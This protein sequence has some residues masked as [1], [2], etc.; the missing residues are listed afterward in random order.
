MFA[1]L[2]NMI[3]LDLISYGDSLKY[4]QINGLSHLWDPIR[5]KYVRNAPEELVRQLLLKHLI[6]TMSYSKRLIQVEKQLMVNDLVRRFDVL[7][8][9]K[10][11][12]PFL[13]VECKA[14]KM[15]ISQKAF[16]QIAQY[17]L[18]LQVPYMLVSNG[19]QHFCCSLNYEDKSYAFLEAIPGPEGL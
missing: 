8:Y 17:N 1:I 3:N 11:M 12:Q 19:I 14:P 15:D 6:E 2:Q 16:D 13:L 10:A 18:S 4:K 9:D 5:Q 7:V